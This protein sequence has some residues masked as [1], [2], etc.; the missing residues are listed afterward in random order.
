MPTN[1]PDIAFFDESCC[2]KGGVQVEVIVFDTV[3]IK[4]TY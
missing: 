1:P 3:A 4:R 2:F